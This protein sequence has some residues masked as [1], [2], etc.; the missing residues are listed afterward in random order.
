MITATV[1]A[2]MVNELPR[3]PSYL[4]I[5]NNQKLVTKTLDLSTDLKA[6]VHF[7]N[8][9]AATGGGDTPEAYELA[10]RDARTFKWR[11]EAGNK[12]V[13]MIGDAPPH[14]P[15]YTTE[16]I[17]WRDELKALADIG[18]KVYGVQCGVD[19]TAKIFFEEMASG[20]GGVY[21][22]SFDEFLFFFFPF[23]QIP[24]DL[25][26][27]SLI[28]EM[29]LAVCYKEFGNEAFEK[30]KAEATSAKPADAGLQ[31]MFNQMSAP[32]AAVQSSAPRLR[33]AW[34]AKEFD[35]NTRPSYKFAG[36]KWV[37][38]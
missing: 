21:L 8:N 32:A 29:F 27:V 38:A 22:G 10:L 7:V 35:K 20:T 13:V 18:V 15:S 4:F 14:P 24:S 3:I 12:A 34:Y 5:N 23:S 1:L 16:K 19:P 37:S 36:A 30:F 2:H 25:T 9:V 11:P 33:E 26:R 31:Q 28:T 6:I 17:W